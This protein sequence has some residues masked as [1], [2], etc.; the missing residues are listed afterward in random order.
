LSG[1]DATAATE[2]RL[3]LALDAGRMGTW[4]WDLHSDE[5]I[6]SAGMERIFGLSPGSFAG[7]LE[8]V[9]AAVHAE[10]REAVMQALA[11]GAAGGREPHLEFRILRPDGGLRWV[12]SWGRLQ[13]DAD[14]RP[15]RLVGIG[16]D[17]TERKRIEEALRLLAEASSVLSASL[18]PDAVLHAVARLVIPLLA[19]CCVIDVVEG[20]VPRRVA[21]HAVPC[22][23]EL[24]RQALA[25][26]TDLSR[27]N[28]PLARA[29]R[30]GEVQL[31]PEL[32]PEMLESLASTPEHRELLGELGV[33]SFLA[34]PLVARG[35]TR[36]AV[37][38]LFGAS[39][40]SHQA[41]EV[42][43]AEELARRVAL[44][45][46]NLHLYQDARQ[47]VRARDQVLAVV[48]HDLR[49]L[50]NPISMGVG[51]LLARGVAGGR[52]LEVI[53]RSA[54][55]ME[56]LI[57]EL[58]DVARSEEGHLVL[59]RER[60]EPAALVR[61]TVESHLAA[62]EQRAL[63]LEGEVASET[64]LVEADR[65]RL[66]RVLANLVGN[67]LKFTPAGGR[68]TVGAAPFKEGEVLF[69][70]GDTGPGIAEEDQQHLFV[71]FWQATPQPRGGTGLGLAI[72]RR[73]VEAHGGRLWVDSAP[74]SGS[75]FSFTVTSSPPPA[76]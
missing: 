43:L 46:D 21:A 48:S 66:L 49:N 37:G 23:E 38:L 30:T 32:T 41:W 31:L 15:R 47:A 60:L 26:S 75:V 28:H 35:K 44:A 62:A 33:R 72:S 52:V 4:E 18:D 53:R 10:D 12:E 14:G 27:K 68:I 54:E 63:R 11:E 67:A 3:R 19:D 8:A 39:G 71:P 51:Q 58:L 45:L 55:Q 1:R 29:I 20:N 34:V 2:E 16:A 25:F 17:R 56:K 57:E 36:G 70:V 5:M 22:H 74:G 6:W 69:W 42:T 9:R 13:A 76:R 7:T 65:H 59:D 24:M 64:P 73:I 40:R 50:L 61:E